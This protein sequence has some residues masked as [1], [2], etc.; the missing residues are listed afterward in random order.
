MKIFRGFHRIAGYLALGP[1]VLGIALAQEE[2][3]N[4]F[5]S[6]PPDV[7]QALKARIAKFYQFF[8]AGKFRQADALVAEDSKD[9]FFAAEKRRFQ[10]FSIGSITYSDNFTTAVA[11]VSCG[12]DQSF[13]GQKFPIKLPLTSFW[14]LEDGEWY[15]YV[16]PPDQQKTYHTPGGDMPRPPTAE[17]QSAASNNQSQASIIRPQISPE[18]LMKAVQLDREMLTFDSSKA[19][20]QEI[21]MTNTLG[22][23]VSVSATTPIKGLKITPAKRELDAK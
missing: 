8:V 14:K 13:M 11:V 18:Q 20:K 19:S 7:D 10:D 4:L 22:G 21:H 23:P 9:I 17:E 2:P 1:L 16:I 5:A 15:W 3:R 12:T 6:A